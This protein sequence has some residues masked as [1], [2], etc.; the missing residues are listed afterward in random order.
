[1]TFWSFWVTATA[2]LLI[3]AII[4][5]PVLDFIF[6]LVGTVPPV[7]ESTLDDVKALLRKGRLFRYSAFRRYRYLVKQPTFA[8]LDGFNSLTR[9]DKQ[10]NA[11]ER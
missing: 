11:S 4:I 7:R 10:R 3:L 8:C 5:W 6:T 2:T 1:M 9:S